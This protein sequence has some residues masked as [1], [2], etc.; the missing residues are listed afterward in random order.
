MNNIDNNDT[1]VRKRWLHLVVA[2][3]RRV[4]RK[5]EEVALT[6]HMPAYNSDSKAR[7]RITVLVND[8]TEA[9]DFVFE[10]QELFDNSYWR[11]VD[12]TGKRPEID[13]HRPQYEG[14]RPDFVD[15]EWEFVLGRMSNPVLQAKMRRWAGDQRQMLAVI[16]C[17]DDADKNEKYS[18]MLKRRL[19][20]S[21]KIE[22]R[23][24]DPAEDARRQEEYMRMGKYVHYFYQMSYNRDQVPTE[25]PEDAVDQAWNALD[26]TLKRS[27]VYNVMSIPV[28]MEILGHD[29][30]DWDTFYALTAE[31]IEILTEVE[32][33]RWCVERLM[34]GSRPCTDKERKEVEK[35]MRLRL[36]DPEYAG[37]NP[38][39]L[40]K[41]YKT[42]R[43]AHYDLCAYSELGVDE[44][45]LP[46][47]R[48]DRDLVAAIP[49]IV[50]TY[51]DRYN[52]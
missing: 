40:K 22:V 12:L 47:T 49:L 27:N 38:V 37:A 14:R 7:T 24:D 11:V 5:A 45:G 35:D 33:N 10:Y 30:S 46:V 13:M 31:E 48:Y 9:Q 29:R 3:D 28:K 6:C 36:S 39:S 34:Q 25:L 41:R 15:V 42:E 2:G 44:T 17:Y 32:H 26:D 16:L 43:N 23:N 20:M 1:D 8:L 21:V 4:Y 52:G 50:K 19:P 18:A 51:H